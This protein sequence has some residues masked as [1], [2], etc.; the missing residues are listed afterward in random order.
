MV[1]ERFAVRATF[2]V[3]GWDVQ[4]YPQVIEAIA[5][6]GHEVAARGYANENFALMRVEQQQ[7]VLDRTEQAF[8]AA[9]GDK[10][11]GWRGPAG[12]PGINDP[13]H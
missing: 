8:V 4:R 6:A 1:F 10:P 13:G 3:P 9:F 5:R 12:L 7:E 11:T 2:F